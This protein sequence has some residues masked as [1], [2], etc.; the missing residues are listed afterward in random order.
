MI[1]RTQAL[2][3]GFFVLVWASLVVLFAAAPEVYYRALKLSSSGAGLLFLVGISAFIALLGVGV[4]RR[5]RWTFWLI[6]VAFLFGVLRIPA[7]VLTLE[8]MLPADEPS[9]YVLYQALLGLVQ[10][11]IAMLMLIGYRRAGTWGRG[12]SLTGGSEIALN[13]SRPS[14][15]ALFT[16]VRRR[17]ILRSS[18]PRRAV[19]CS[20]WN[21]EDLALTLKH[22]AS[23]KER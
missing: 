14:R 11:A 10:F 8:G 4:L 6:A 2:V 3:L 22:V 16:R 23:P 12:E 9:W 18:A 7:S 5:W 20:L 15:L 13:R 19:G 1:N 17:L 21:I